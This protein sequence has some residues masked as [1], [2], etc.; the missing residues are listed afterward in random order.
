M[1]K[2]HSVYSPLVSVIMPAHNA[3]LFLADAIDSILAQTYPNYELII[4]ND[5]STDKTG[6]I[7]QK[8]S[9]KSD[10]IELI[11]LEKNQGES[12]AANL[13]FNQSQ[14]KYIARMDAD[15]ISHPERLAKQVQFLENHPDHILV[16]SQAYIIDS[17]NQIIGQKKFPLHNQEIYQ[18]Y[19]VLHPV[20]HPSIMVRRSMLPWEDKLWANQA[21]PNDDYYTLFNLLKCGKFANLDQKLVHYRMHDNNK[22]MQDVK[23]KFINSV[24]IRYYAVTKL[25]YP[26]SLNMALK[27]L[28][29]ALFVLSMPE[30]L[31]IGLYLVL[32]G[33]KPLNQAFPNLSL[34]SPN[35]AR[36]FILTVSKLSLLRLLIL[37]LRH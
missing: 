4:I 2:Q 9:Q 24:K 14:G 37:K 5:G 10:K 17:H 32:R 23:K 21:E 20:L 33:M 22:S 15:D 3:E 11:N 35:L 12:A 16:G 13:G 8:Y 25:D 6:Q 1:N 34:T 31:T 7:S 27:V 19:G 18:E 30:K 28:I 36:T 26:L 29:Q